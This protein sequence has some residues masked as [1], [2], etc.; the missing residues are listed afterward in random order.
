MKLIVSLQNHSNMYS[1]KPKQMKPKRSVSITGLKKLIVHR[2]GLLQEIFPACL[3]D[4]TSLTTL[5]LNHACGKYKQINY[6]VPK[7]I[8]NLINLTTLDIHVPHGYVNLNLN[9]LL[10]NPIMYN[11]ELLY[12]SGIKINNEEFEKI[13]CLYGLKNLRMWSCGITHIPKKISNLSALQDLDLMYNDLQNHDFNE[14]LCGLKNLTNLNL[15]TCLINPKC[16]PKR[17]TL[18]SLTHLIIGRNKLD[19][20]NVIMSDLINL[21]HLNISETCI[22]TFPQGIEYLPNLKELVI[23]GNKLTFIPPTLKLPKLTNLSISNCSLTIIPSFI[24]KL[25]TLETLYIDRNNFNNNEQN[26]TWCKAILTVPEFKNLLIMSDDLSEIDGF[27]EMKNYIANH[28]DYGQ[29]FRI[30]PIKN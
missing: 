21:T 25:K 30:T 20:N 18:K 17:I 24:I 28:Y 29:V 26:S 10:T 8:N 27:L 23:G 7:E 15:S 16:F 2:Y 1:T 5:Y 4:M 12:L 6:D 22:N 3:C 13:C 9:N 14:S 11:I 19:L